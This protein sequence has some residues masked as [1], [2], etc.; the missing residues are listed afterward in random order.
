MLKTAGYVIRDIV[1]GRVVPAY[2]GFLLAAG[3]GLF[4]FDAN[5]DKGLVG[6]L[7]LVLLVTPLAGLVFGTIHYYHSY[8]FL[9]LLAAQPVRRRTLLMAEFLGM[10][11][12]LGTAVLV[13]VGLPVACYAPGATGAVLTAAAV[14][15]TLV[16]L[17]L[18][19]LGAVLTRDKA[20]GIGLALLLWFH[21]ALLH[22]GLMVLVMTLFGDYPLEKP[23]VAMICLNPIDLARVTVL[24]RLDVSALMGYTGALMKDLFGTGVGMICGAAVLLLWLGA[25]LLL[26]VRLFDRK[27]L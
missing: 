17:A 1:R 19:L 21:F 7:S 22:D 3:C 20:R 26:A 6:L 8:E 15:L 9:E 27:D 13:G 2:A 5:P 25:P 16:F 14:A 24:L 4:Q 10:A 12:G 18:G 23:A 11:A